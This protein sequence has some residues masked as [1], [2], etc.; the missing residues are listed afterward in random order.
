M[1]MEW[2]QA[3]AKDRGWRIDYI[4]GN[5]AAKARTKSVEIDRQGGLEVS[6]HAPVILDLH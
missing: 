2:L 1:L 5:K 4:L 6:D 3:R